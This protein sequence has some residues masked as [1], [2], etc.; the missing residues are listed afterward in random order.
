MLPKK[1]IAIIVC[2]LLCVGIVIGE[3]I[4]L[5]SS[6]QLLFERFENTSIV[7]VDGKN[8]VIGEVKDANGI[9]RLI[10]EGKIRYIDGIYMFDVSLSSLDC[11]LA[12]KEFCGITEVYTHRYAIEEDIIK[13]YLDNGVLVKIVEDG[14]I[15]AE[16]EGYNFVG[17]G[18]KSKSIMF[19]KKGCYLRDFSN[20]KFADYSVFR[21]YEY[22][23][24]FEFLT[25]IC[26][27]AS[28]EYT[29]FGND[30]VSFV[31]RVRVQFSSN[32]AHVVG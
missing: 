5:L 26:N 32:G 2:V 4:P 23:E 22:E 16:Y 18:I 1:F 3:N 7:N 17:F 14:P 11:V 25:G 21:T 31:K 8:Y 13:E 10:N 9:K 6:N 12:C 15:S 19:V 28:G 20:S 24:Y 30:V 29:D 27:N